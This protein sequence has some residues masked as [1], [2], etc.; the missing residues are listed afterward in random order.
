MDTVDEEE[1]ERE[2]EEVDRTVLEVE[3]RFHHQTAITPPDIKAATPQL[4]IEA[5]IEEED[6]VDVLHSEAHVGDLDV[7]LGGMEDRHSGI[8]II[9]IQMIKLKQLQIMN[10]SPGE[11]SNLQRSSQPF[12]VI[13][14]S[15]RSN[16]RTPSDTSKMQ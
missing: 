2:E 8:Q 4:E 5:L 6:L 12:L 14:I 3:D 10:P 11:R 13:I 9:P 7:A 1:E 15:R 16:K